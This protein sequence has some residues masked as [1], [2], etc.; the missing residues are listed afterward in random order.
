[1]AT[2]PPS[3]RQYQ[4]LGSTTPRGGSRSTEF[5][6]SLERLWDEI[7]SVR[8]QQ[9]EMTDD[10][11]VVMR[12]LKVDVEEH[13]TRISALEQQ[14]QSDGDAVVPHLRLQVDSILDSYNTL[15]T[16][17][18]GEIVARTQ[19]VDL[20]HQKLEDLD[21][22]TADDTRTVAQAVKD[23]ASIARKAA[24]GH[25]A[26]QPTSRRST[27]PSGETADDL[28]ADRVDSAILSA[29][30]RQR[31]ASNLLE[32]VRTMHAECSTLVAEFKFMKPASDSISLVSSP[33]GGS[34]SHL[35]GKVEALSKRL[36]DEVS[37]R[38]ME[39]AEVADALET[40]EQLCV[41][42]R[43]SS[44]RSIQQLEETFKAEIGERIMKLFDADSESR[45]SSPKVASPQHTPSDAAKPD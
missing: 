34:L 25:A 9:E 3:P 17:L 1:M 42:V 29:Q 43:N 4:R 21:R 45:C 16:V 33:R 7:T 36:E 26:D 13:R 38:K 11:A 18:K 30:Q 28:R 22:R 23:V 8:K 14:R 32:E 5:M 12:H 37:D 15:N 6:A 10:A 35:T 2:L 44:A 27:S 40:L 41:N 20:L 39:G 31:L 24:Q 19:I